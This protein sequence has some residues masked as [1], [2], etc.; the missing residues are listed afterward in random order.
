[1]YSQLTVRLKSPS[2][3]AS[4]RAA[5]DADPRYNLEA[6]REDRYYEEASGPLATFVRALGTVI[7]VFFAFG[8]TMGAMITMYAQVASRVREEGTLRALGVGRRAVLATFLIGGLV[9]AVF[10]GGG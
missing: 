3:L 8:A 7:A 6:K 1:G 10:V 4:L 2:E 9:L 5:V